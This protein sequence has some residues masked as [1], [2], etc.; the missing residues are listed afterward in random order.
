MKLEEQ[1]CHSTQIFWGFKIPRRILK[2]PTRRSTLWW[3]SRSQKQNRHHL[4]IL[5]TYSNEFLGIKGQV[6]RSK[7][8]ERAITCTSGK[9]NQ[10]LAAH[11]R[12]L[13]KP[14][15]WRVRPIRSRKNRRQI[16]PDLN[17]CST[18]PELPT[19]FSRAS[20][21]NRWI[22]INR[23]GRNKANYPTFNWSCKTSTKSA[24]FSRWFLIRKM[25]NR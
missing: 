12:L 10:W 21:P 8:L 24:A 18:T 23:A 11:S 4:R 19:K 1:L 7:S 15:Y 3:S 9:T 20:I 14:L 5:T 13:R 22:R 16:L 6:K 2:D 25:I 17:R